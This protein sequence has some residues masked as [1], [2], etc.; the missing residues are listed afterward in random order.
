[1][2][3]RGFV[4]TFLLLDFV[5]NDVILNQYMYIIEGKQNQDEEHNY[6]MKSKELKIMSTKEKQNRYRK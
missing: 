2:H 3:R 1:L 6:M 4:F 5:E